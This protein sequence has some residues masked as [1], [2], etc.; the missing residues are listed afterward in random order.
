MELGGAPKTPDD[1]RV[2]TLGMLGSWLSGGTPSKKRADFWNGQIP[3][4]SAK[5][6][7][8]PRIYDAIDHVTEAALGNGARTAPAGAVL[9]VIRGMILAHTLPVA[10]AMRRVAFNQDLKAFLPRDGVVGEFVLMWLRSRQSRLLSITSESTHGTKTIP[11]KALLAEQIA[12]PSSLE[13]QAIAQALADADAL[14]E[15]LEQL[16][17]KKRLI[18][19]GAM[20][21]L[22]TGKCRLPGCRSHWTE[23]RLKEI[24]QTFGGLS[25]KSSRDFGRGDGRYVTFMNVISNVI[26]DKGMLERVDVGPQESQNRVKSGDLLLN[27]SSETPNEVALCSVVPD[28]VDGVFLNSFCFGFRFHS[29]AP[30]EGLYWAYYLR[31]DEGRKR[32]KA[33][34]QGAIRYNVSKTAFLNTAFLAPGRDEQLAIA[35][36]LADVDAELT[37]L[38]AKLAKARQ[39]KQ[40]M[41]QNLL[42]G[43]IRLV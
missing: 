16:L 17:A 32:V 35:G 36:V 41:M 5:D 12:L 39:I 2:E 34:A 15:S 10:L 11:T 29:D 28:G 9:L 25:G 24:G 30:A 38:E 1:W 42:T 31:S 8:V 27:G 23:V 22:F 26:V 13:Q 7:K 43:K 33:L 20:Q 14:I 19:Q 6:M 37:A 4:I 3:W 40:G 18:K 21:V